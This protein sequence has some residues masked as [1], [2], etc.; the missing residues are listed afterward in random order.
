MNLFIIYGMESDY[1]PT[2]SILLL[3][4]PLAFRLFMDW[5][6]I[7]KDKKEVN[8]IMSTLITGALMLVCCS[9]DLNQGHA[10]FFIQPILMS[11]GIF[12]MFFDYSLNLLR[13]K[14]WYY[15]DEEKDGVGS[16]S[17]LLYAK[18]GVWGTLFFK[19]WFLLVT[20]SVYFYLS[21]YHLKP[22]HMNPV[23][24]FT[25]GSIVAVLFCAFA[26][27]ATAEKH[28]ADFKA[29]IQN[30]DVMVLTA[31]ATFYLKTVSIVS[32]EII[33]VKFA[34]LA[35]CAEIAPDHDL[36]DYIVQNRWRVINYNRAEAIKQTSK[37]YAEALI[38]PSRQT[39]PV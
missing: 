36:T 21:F 8:H 35:S 1:G 7:T 19:V 34:P 23:K 5:Y 12:F 28:A 14:S 18:W 37:G 4:L 16:L 22:I 9:A 17:D 29:H 13:G 32:A 38:P 3:F 6:T 39:Y 25:R 10:R 2:W 24:L 15:I 27:M 20:F 30:I 11:W 33:S 31:P 26:S